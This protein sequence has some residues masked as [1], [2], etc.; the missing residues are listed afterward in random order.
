MACITIKYD[1]GK[2]EGDCDYEKVTVGAF[3]SSSEKKEFNTGNLAVDWFHLWYYLTHSGNFEREPFIAYTS[4]VDHFIMD[5]EAYK[6]A[7]LVY[8]E[9]KGLHELVHDYDMYTE[10]MTI[11]VEKG[12]RPTWDEHRAY[13]R[14]KLGWSKEEV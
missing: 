9:E 6:I 14:E 8:D 4:S 10:G 2:R 12:H 11:F 5:N 3:I 7:I 13:C 1:E